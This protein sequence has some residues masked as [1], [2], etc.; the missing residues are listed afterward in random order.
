MKLDR[1]KIL[2][3]IIIGSIIRIILVCVNNF[4]FDFFPDFYKFNLIYFSVDNSLWILIVI[5]LFLYLRKYK[6]NDLNRIP[7]IIY[8]LV[9]FS[10]IVYSSIKGSATEDNEI[11]KISMIKGLLIA[12]PYLIMSIQLIRSDS[13]DKITKYIRWIGV[14]FLFPWGYAIL[15]SILTFGK[16]FNGVEGL[17]WIQ[18]V[19]NTLFLF[20]IILFCFKEKIYIDSVF[21][22]EKQIDEQLGQE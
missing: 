15:Y 7:V 8:C 3:W 11:T 14:S 9:Y 16:Q 20:L 17:T 21:S 10:S 6:L 19:M 18:T 5:S 1:Q 4:I 12:I 13:K 2:N 22:F